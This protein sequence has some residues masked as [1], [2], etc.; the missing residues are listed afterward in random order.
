LYADGCGAGRALHALNVRDARIYVCLTDGDAELVCRSP[1]EWPCI[2]HPN[3]HLTINRRG[4]SVRISRIE[5][6][7]QTTL[8]V[9]TPSG[10]TLPEFVLSAV[11]PVPHSRLATCNGQRLA[12]RVVHYVGSGGRVVPGAELVAACE[13]T[14]AGQPA[15]LDRYHHAG[16]AGRAC[17]IERVPC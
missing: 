15:D 3:C 14:E 4:T 17:E 8:G 16:C 5:K 12:R 13:P 2:Q 9:R 1:L 6:H 7:A 10:Q 11:L